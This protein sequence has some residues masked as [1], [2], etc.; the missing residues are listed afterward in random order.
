MIY[1]CLVNDTPV[2]R[3]ELFTTHDQTTNVYDGP[4]DHGV[5]FSAA[6]RVRATPP[7]LS[8]S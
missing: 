8:M 4:V 7:R 3:D 1:R 6:W 2:W 5:M